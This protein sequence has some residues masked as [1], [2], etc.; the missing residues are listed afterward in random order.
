MKKTV[1]ISIA[2]IVMSFGGSFAVQAQND[3][4]ASNDAGVSSF[5][6]DYINANSEIKFT[7]NKFHIVMPAGMF[8]DIFDGTF[9]PDADTGTIKLN[10]DSLRVGQSRKGFNKTAV[11]SC[12]L[13]NET[14]NVMGI[15]GE[16]AN[17]LSEIKGEYSK[18]IT[19]ESNIIYKQF[20]GT[21]NDKKG[22][23][24]IV[25]TGNKFHISIPALL[26]IYT[27]DGTFVSD[28][29][30][31]TL[32]LNI[33]S[34]I[35]GR[36]KTVLDHTAFLSYNLEDDKLNITDLTAG[37]VYVTLNNV[38]AEYTK[39]DEDKN[40]A[41]NNVIEGAYKEIKG[42]KQLTF[43]ENTFRIVVPNMIN[44]FIYEGTFETDT[45]VGTIKLY[46]TNQTVAKMRQE[47]Y[48]TVVLSYNLE[49]GILN[50]THVS[51]GTISDVFG[52][53]KGKYSVQ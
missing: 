11:L 10:F 46:V 26:L 6:G 18:T 52:K 12:K 43:S 38:R 34:M 24:H 37:E 23:K 4:S 36:I 29:K 13:E 3:E 41:E 21:F 35:S 44:T 48:K 53:I 22:T 33:N 7:G 25:F 47:L 32:K 42:K 50:I 28:M 30:M 2:L 15:S 17:S 45:S 9:E 19:D 27:F 16:A 39:I 49:D 5:E 1:I 40:F 31:K 14:L 20:N 8:T 51:G